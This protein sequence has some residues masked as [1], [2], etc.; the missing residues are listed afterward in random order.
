VLIERR[1]VDCCFGF[2]PNPV[3]ARRAADPPGTVSKPSACG[4]SDEPN[5]SI[6]LPIAGKPG[7]CAFSKS[8]CGFADLLAFR[9]RPKRVAAFWR[10]IGVTWRKAMLHLR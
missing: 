7:F 1:G 9:S 3:G 5:S 6:L 10:V 2:Q 4:V 8:C